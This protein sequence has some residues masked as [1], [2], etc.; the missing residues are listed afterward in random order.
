MSCSISLDEALPS[1]MKKLACFS[2]IFAPP[3]LKPF[4]PALSNSF[5]AELFLGF[6]NKLPAD[7]LS[8][9]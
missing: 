1:F 5:P 7:L 4:N 6:L 3:I 9:G 2:D 8:S